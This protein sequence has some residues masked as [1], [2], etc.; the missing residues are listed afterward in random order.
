MSEEP[1]QSMKI[2]KPPVDEPKWLNP[3]V[4]PTCGERASMIDSREAYNEHWNC[5]KCGVHRWEIMDR[6]Y[7]GGVPKNLEYRGIIF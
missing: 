5:P 2:E 3:E 6:P 4:C 7:N 1:I